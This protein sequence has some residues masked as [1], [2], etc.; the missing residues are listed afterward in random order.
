MRTRDAVLTLVVL[1]AVAACKTPPAPDPTGD[2]AAIRA[3]DARWLAAA[4][5]HD[6]E[7]SVSYWSDD[8]ILL[9]AGSPAIVGRDAIRRYVTGAFAIPDFSISWTMD[10]ISVAKSGD[11]AYATGTNRISL[12]TPEGRAVLENNR[13]VEVWR[14]ERDGSWRC[15][16]D[17]ANSSGARP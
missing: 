17:I 14:K 6:I 16:V 4:Q 11:L 1:G 2:E 10:H 5:A 8:A 9:I 3:A 13:A 12:T 15:V 7:Q